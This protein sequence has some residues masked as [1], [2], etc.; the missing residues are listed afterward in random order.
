MSTQN[1]RNES[2][3]SPSRSSLDPKSKLKERLVAGITGLGKGV[4]LIIEALFIAASKI[5]RWS[6]R[7]P[8]I[9]R[10]TLAIMII[11]GGFIFIFL[12]DETNRQMIFRSLFP[13]YLAM[14]ISFII[15]YLYT[16]QIRKR[17]ILA[18]LRRAYLIGLQNSPLNPRVNKGS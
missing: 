6:R 17:A 15:T 4:F 3:R 10:G 9:F 11:I 2:P 1:L 13:I 8:L 16:T 14:I 5:A 18:K 12:P 7:F